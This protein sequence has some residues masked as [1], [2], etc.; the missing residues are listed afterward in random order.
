[1]RFSA[2]STLADGRDSRRR[3]EPLVLNEVKVA[4]DVQQ[5][6]LEEFQP[7]LLK[8][9]A[10][11]ERMLHAFRVRWRAQVQLLQSL[12]VLLPGLAQKAD[13]A[14]CQQPVGD[15][16]LCATAAGT[17]MSALHIPDSTGGA[18]HNELS[19]NLFR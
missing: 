18:L 9:L 3:L 12:L 13:T 2:S 10:L 4:F 15:I 11:V 6:L 16:L 5:S 17:S 1:M 7:P 8:V 19:K 14:H